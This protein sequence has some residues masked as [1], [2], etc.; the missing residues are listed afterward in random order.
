MYGT[1]DANSRD[2]IIIRLN[3]FFPR[4]KQVLNCSENP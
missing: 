4:G 3:K 2:S 1:R